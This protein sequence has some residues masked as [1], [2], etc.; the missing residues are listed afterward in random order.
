L[1]PLAPAGARNGNHAENGPARCVNTE[2]A[3]TTLTALSLKHLASGIAGV[4]GCDAWEGWAMAAGI[5]L[6]FVALELAQLSVGDRVRRQIAR[7]AKP[8][9]I[10]TLAGSATM[11]AVAFGAQAANPYLMAAGKTENLLADLGRILTEA[12][13]NYDGARLDRC[14]ASDRPETVTPVMCRRIM[15]AEKL[16]CERFNYS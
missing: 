1:Q 16:L 2:P 5:D 8:A 9:I 3:L 13:E 14:N 4:T 7:F 6:G 10:G 11:N 12:G 15:D